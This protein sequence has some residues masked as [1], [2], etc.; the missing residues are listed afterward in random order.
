VKVVDMTDRIAVDPE[1]FEMIPH[2]LLF[3]DLSANALRI[4][5][6][7]RKHRDWQT[8]MCHPGR[9]RLA[10]L[11]H[12][13]LST[14]KR[15]LVNLSRVGAITITR[16]KTESGE[17]DTNLYCIHWEPHGVIHRGS[18]KNPPRFTNNPG[19]GSQRATNKDP[20]NKEV[21]PRWI[22]QLEDG[23]EH[24]AA[25]LAFLQGKLV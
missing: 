9:R 2:W 20:L 3:S 7:L 4:W 24:D 23:P 14:V 15:E 19:G 18:T 10:D 1:P 22:E 6:V 25:Y 5:L 11:C 13:S 8:G 16:R 12:V 17:D 21:V